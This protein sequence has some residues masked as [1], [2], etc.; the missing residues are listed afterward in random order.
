M[1]A[2]FE[3]KPGSSYDDR[4]DRYEFPVQYLP[5]AQ[6]AIGDWAVFRSIG[7]DR[8]TA[9]NRPISDQKYHAVAHV[10]DVIPS[11][12]ERH[13]YAILSD[14]TQFSTRVPLRHE[15]GYFET[16]LRTIPSKSIGFR[17]QGRSVRPLEDVDFYAIAAAG[18]H[19]LLDEDTAIRLQIDSDR[20]DAEARAALDAANAEPASRAIVQVLL[21]KKLREANFRDLVLAAYD[22]TCA[23]TG[24]RIVNGGGKAE[25]QAAHIWAVKHGGPDVV[26]NGIALSGT[27]HWLFDRH[28][29]TLTDDYGLLVSHNK[30][31]SEMMNLIGPRVER[32]RLPRD[33]RQHPSPRYIA[34]HRDLFMAA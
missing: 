16:W 10:T 19:R 6:R 21:N 7:R 11:H 33:P 20:M 17:M 26:Q 3:S 14:Y 30:I 25:V 23:A 18:L 24:I 34:K 2:V 1:K 27:A 8:D 13:Y 9:T 4:P 29:M 28:L 15:F 31:P 12:R 22:E 32:I 5:I